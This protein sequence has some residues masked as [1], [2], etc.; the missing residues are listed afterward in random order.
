MNVYIE[1]THTNNIKYI[2]KSGTGSII[3]RRKFRGNPP[4]LCRQT[5]PYYLITLTGSQVSKE[6][7][8]NWLDYYMNNEESDKINPQVAGI[9]D[10]PEV[11]DSTTL[12]GKNVRTKR[13]IPEQLDEIIDIY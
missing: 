1:D 3:A 5:E 10:I 7:V 11:I 4:R 6:A 8:L 9:E 13:L 12:A 2:T